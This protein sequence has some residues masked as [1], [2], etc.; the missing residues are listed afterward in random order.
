MNPRGFRDAFRDI[1]PVWLS[2]R[3]EKN[4]GYRLLWMCF[5]IL[6]VAVEAVI[7]VARAALPGLGGTSTALPYIGRSRGILRGEGE[8][9]ASYEERLREWLDTWD[10]AGSDETLAKQIQFYLAN[11][12]M[13]RIITR[14]GHVTTLN[15]DGTFSY[16]TCAWD[17]DS[18]SNPVRAGYWSDLWIVIYPCEWAIT[19]TTL[20]S[21]V[22][23]WGHHTGLG[24][25]H[26]VPRAA[27]DAITMLVTTWRAAHTRVRAIIWSYDATLIDPAN[28]A[29]LPDGW[30]GNW[31]KP[32]PA[33]PGHTIRSRSPNARYWVPRDVHPADPPN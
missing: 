7:Q 14:A 25:G 23:I 18:H 4:V 16:A 15:P 33:N 26:A 10:G 17:W 1:V 6:D 21:L 24:T 3:L 20:A 13:V 29:S 27:V 9:D 12:P 32:D 2:N 19:G 28:P 30:W 5:V 8:S 22:G 11:T 31:G